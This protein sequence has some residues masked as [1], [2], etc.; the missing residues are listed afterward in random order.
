VLSHNGAVSGFNAY[1]AVVPSTRSAVIMACNL[2]GGMSSL[3][4]QIFSLLLKEPS[5]V[6]AIAGPN[7]AATVKAMFA[8]LQKGKVNRQQFSEEFNHYLTDK[9]VLGAAKRLKRY[10]NPKKAEVISASERGSMEVTTT[11]LTFASGELRVLMYRT[12]VGKIEQFFVSRE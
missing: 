4:G 10:G 9:K 12:P 7:A 11:R 1:N 8:Q 5:N 3:P 2:E 6:P